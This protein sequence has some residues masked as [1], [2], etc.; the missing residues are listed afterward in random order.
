MTASLAQPPVSGGDLESSGP[1]FDCLLYYCTCTILYT[2]STEQLISVEYTTVYKY[3]CTLNMLVLYLYVLVRGYISVGMQLQ[4][5]DC[6][7]QGS[8]GL[9]L[10]V[11]VQYQALPS[12]RTQFCPS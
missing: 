8:T 1:W 4:P 9:N 5:L 6:V 10:P 3:Y 7:L 11:T 12:I 2:I